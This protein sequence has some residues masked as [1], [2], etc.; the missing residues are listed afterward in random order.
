MNSS[1]VFK[2]KEEDLASSPPSAY[3]LMWMGLRVNAMILQ[4]S[5]GG[6][7]PL[8]HAICCRL[9]MPEEL[10]P[11]QGPISK[12]DRAVAIMSMGCHAS[13]GSGPF[14]LQCEPR[15]NSLVTGESPSCSNRLSGTL[16][17]R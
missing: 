17:L 12:D 13:S 10:P 8:S 11:T 4:L 15:G 14:A 2:R 9:C 5:G 3:A 1:N 7:V 16:H 6:L